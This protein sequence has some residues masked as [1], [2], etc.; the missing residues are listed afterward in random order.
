MIDNLMKGQIKI[1]IE[2]F[3]KEVFI[4]SFKEN[5]VFYIICNPLKISKK[6][7]HKNTLYCI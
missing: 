4:L 3:N 7:Q 6:G 2:L 5:K 1:I